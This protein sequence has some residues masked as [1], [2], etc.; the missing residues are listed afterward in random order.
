MKVQ[1][2]SPF[3]SFVAALVLFFSLFAFNG[4]GKEAL[5]LD[6]SMKEA[7]V[8]V[9]TEQLSEKDS[10]ESTVSTPATP[11]VT[12]GLE[13]VNTLGAPLPGLLS[14]RPALTSTSS[15]LQPDA[16][17]W[18]ALPKHLRPQVDNETLWLARVIYSET[19]RPEEQE[20]VAWVVR[21]RVET[22]YRNN[23]TYRDAVLDSYQFSAFN[24]GTRTRKHYSSLGVHST[25]AGWQKALR[26]AY[27]VKNMPAQYR[28]FDINTRHFYSEQSMVGQRHP[29]WAKG[30]SPVK[31]NRSY[32]LE[33]RR[34]RFFADIT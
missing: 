4:D 26:I 15:L 9:Q 27:E 32:F 1:L 23:K 17:T 11:R 19:K 16:R 18:N 3:Y 22:G 14:T 6:A 31:P 28:P 25:E 33:A 13:G 7:S 29:A 21:N 12:V 24:P 34:F 8:D 10:D 2:T 20:L 5:G 30:Q